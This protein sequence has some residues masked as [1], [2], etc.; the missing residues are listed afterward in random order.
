[1]RITTSVTATLQQSQ[2][3]DR[4]DINKNYEKSRHGGL[5]RLDRDLAGVFGD[6]ENDKV[7]RIKEEIKNGT[8]R[9][10]LAATADR[11]AR[12]LLNA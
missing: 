1:M 7:S 8:Y 9:L 5:D 3:R 11:M 12:S 4:N 6:R 2:S 10:D